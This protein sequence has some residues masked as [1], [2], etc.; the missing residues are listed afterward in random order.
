MFCF[1]FI[2]FF[3]WEMFFCFVLFWFSVVFF[4][5][6]ILL[7]ILSERLMQ[8]LFKTKCIIT[9]HISHHCSFLL[10][11]SRTIT[12]LFRI[13]NPGPETRVDLKIKQAGPTQA[14]IGFEE[15]GKRAPSSLSE[16][17]RGKNKTGPFNLNITL[18]VESIFY[19]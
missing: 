18:R 2:S 17:K 3:P 15:D 12:S 16:T 10:K 4:L 8:L 5:L 11:R 7:I 13:Q 14:L 6:S 1:V 19:E 9:I